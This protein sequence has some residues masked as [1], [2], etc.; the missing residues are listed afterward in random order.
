MATPT[1]PMYI[2]K[3]AQDGIIEFNKSCETVQESD[4]NIR[5]HLREIDLAYMREQDWTT[6]HKRAKL[7]NRYGDSDK[8]QNIT[9]PVVM[10]QV[11]SAVAYQSSVFLTGLPIFE[12]VANP[13][14]EDQALQLNTIIEDQSIKGGWVRELQMFFRDGFKYNI[15]ALEVGWD[16]VV[17]AALETDLTYSTK[18]A[19][20][21]SVQWEGNVISRLDPYNTLRDTRCFPTEIPTKGE[22]AG[23]TKLMSR[24]AL[25]DFIN[26]LPLKIIENIIPAFE[27]G[28][29]GS[30]NTLESYYIPQLN[31]DALLS[32]NLRASTDWASWVTAS[33]TN[34]DIQYRNLYEVRVLYGR[35][36]PSDFSLKVPAQN[37]PQ[38]WKFIIVNNQVI[39]S[40]ERQT[41][42]HNMIPILFG[43]PY[44]DGLGYQT[45]SLA[46]NA[47]P[48]QQAASALLNQSFA[49][50]RR[51]IFDRGLYD[52]SRI[53]SAAVNNSNPASKI[54]VKP[55]AYNK[56]VGDAYMPLPFKDDQSG[57]VFDKM[58]AL[59][60]MTDEV[61]GRNRAQRGLF[62]KGNRTK[63]EY[64]DVQQNAS[65]RDHMVSM[66]LEA[67]VFTPLKEMLK[68]N[69][70][71]YQGGT[72]LYS[73]QQ[74][75]L[76]T[77]DPVALRTAVLNFKMADGLTPVSKQIDSDALQVAM[78]VIGS[79]PQIAAEYNMGPAF[80]YLMKVQ[81]ADLKPFEKTPQQVAY[82]Q[83][84]QQWQ[85]AMQTIAETA[86]KLNQP[87]D[88]KMLP[89][90]PLPEQFGYVPGSAP[91]KQPTANG[92]SIL[93]QVIATTQQPATP[94]TQQPPGVI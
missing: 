57:I 3:L 66:L 91:Q 9:V 29:G 70:L 67:Q 60:G 8:L 5:E 69:V 41:N 30:G 84:S 17:T 50:S 47:L 40:A 71:Q 6:E 53:D 76:V 58:Q 24:V 82:E 92:P 72:T 23:Y 63:E 46:T 56:P 83:A 65:G 33:R 39:I 55:A 90:Q 10:P 1:V 18:E 22:F 86:A 52:P 43:V 64:V 7:A 73:S 32:R 25:K 89:P 45:K 4:Y 31:Q 14:F 75:Q 62:T 28:I 74:Q 54:P 11:E 79:N 26:K 51:S 68:I 38:V 94:M 36:I 13:Q 80:S 2:P 88:P 42:A 61:T 59:A 87:L 35:I 93:Q 48:F 81:G 19:K 44:E 21:K 78:Q 37:T 85:M 16:S 20:P 27:S 15:S 34:S 77:I 49:A 12:S